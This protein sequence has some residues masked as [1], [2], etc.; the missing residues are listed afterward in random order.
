[1]NISDDICGLLSEYYIHTYCTRLLNPRSRAAVRTGSVPIA[2]RSA[3]IGGFMTLPL[4]SLKSLYASFKLLPYEICWKQFL[5]QIH[6]TRL[7]VTLATVQAMDIHNM[8]ISMVQTA[9]NDSR[10]DLSEAAFLLRE[11]VSAW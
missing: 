1:M 5:V 8:I 10:Y 6:R 3:Y 4:E 9:F 7:M 11:S 2:L